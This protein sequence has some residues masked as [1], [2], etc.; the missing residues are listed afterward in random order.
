[1]SKTP[2]WKSTAVQNLIRY[3]PSG[4]Y[5]ARFKVGGK[6][7]WKSLKTDVFSVARWRLPDT[8]REYRSHAELRARVVRG[9]VLVADAA[10]LYLEKTRADV[11]LKPRSKQY[12]ETLIGFIRRSW[13]TLFELDVQKVKESDSRE[14]LR[15]SSSGMRLLL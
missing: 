5:F 4:T 7:I 1:M 3:E 14:W 9:K 11:S 15:I 10:N 13:P 8:L 6:S 12:R 2:K